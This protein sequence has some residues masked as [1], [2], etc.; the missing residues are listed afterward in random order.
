[1]LNILQFINW[2][3]QKQTHKMTPLF[4]D[5]CS[6]KN[7]MWE[8]RCSYLRVF[9]LS[10]FRVQSGCQIQL[11]QQRISLAVVPFS[12]RQMSRLKPR[13][14]L[15]AVP[16][17]QSAIETPT[18]AFLDCVSLSLPSAG[19]ASPWMGLCQPFGPLR[20]QR[21]PLRSTAQ[22][23]AASAWPCVS[24]GYYCVTLSG[25]CA[26]LLT[27]SLPLCLFV[28]N[29]PQRQLRSLILSLLANPL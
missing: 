16:Q 21:W 9:L 25:S 27:L 17:L 5:Q 6:W 2:R 22:L 3:K 28:L 14:N 29:A 26:D 18:F 19:P 1:M 7:P 10:N 24:L 4:L 20:Q 15:L 23:L 11:T 8:N 13:I 12:L